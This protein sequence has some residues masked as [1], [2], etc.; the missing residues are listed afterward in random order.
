M[1]LHHGYKTSLPVNKI[2]G[3]YP[4]SFPSSFRLQNICAGDSEDKSGVC[5]HQSG[6]RFEK[7]ILIAEKKLQF[8]ESEE[9]KP[10]VQ[11]VYTFSM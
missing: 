6:S 5:E 11:I 3:S 2:E 8:V 1:S 10:L 9:Y 7:G 4:I